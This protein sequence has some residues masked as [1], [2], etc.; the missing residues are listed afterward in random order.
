MQN[1]SNAVTADKTHMKTGPDKVSE[2]VAEKRRALGRGLESLL[3]GPRVTKAIFEPVQPERTDSATGALQHPSPSSPSNLGSAGTAATPTLS[4]TPSAAGRDGD[5]S[6][7]SEPS[8]TP[9]GGAS[10]TAVNPSASVDNQAAGETSVHGEEVVRLALDRVQDNPYQT[11]HTF[12]EKALKELAQSI[13]TQG[14]LQPIVVR[15]GQD[16]YFKLILGERRL[17]ASRLAEMA[18]IP[19]IIKR[20]SDQQ[21]AEMTIVENLQRQDLNCVDQAE[22]FATLSTKFNLTQEQIGARVGMSRETVSNYMRLVTLGDGI[23]E[24]L[25]KGTLTFSHARALLRVQDTS[26]R[27]TLAKKAIEEKMS[28]ARL[29]DLVQGMVLPRESKR[30]APEGGARWVDPNVR[31]A[32]R[33]LEEVLGM[34]VRIRDQHGRGKIVIEYGTIDDF[35]R[36]VMMLKGK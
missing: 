35:D 25:L 6:P 14:V 33:S 20:V 27:W 15:P 13:R 7:Q 2:K 32:Q 12:D 24:A 21:A 19:A 26:L 8:E 10:A 23:I 30:S 1:T 29:E 22:A 5:S 31:A 34:R 4:P 3:P 18:E 17:R 16:G 11:R 9:S 36:V 28:V